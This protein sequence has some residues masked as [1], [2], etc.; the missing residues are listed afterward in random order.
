MRNTMYLVRMAPDLPFKS[1]AAA[2]REDDTGIAAAWVLAG[3]LEPQQQRVTAAPREALLARLDCA[4][5]LPLTVVISPPG[6]GKTTLLSQWHGSLRKRDDIAVAWLSLE[7]ED[8]EVSRFVVY[9]ALAIARAGVDL[10]PLAQTTRSQLHDIDA[11]GAIAALLAVI[12]ALPRRLVIVLDDYDRTRSQTVDDV[13]GRLIRHG[14]AQLHVVISSRS[15]PRLPLSDLTVRG[16]VERIEASDLALSMEEARMVLGSGI[17]S[18]AVRQLHGRTEGWAVALQL[19]G[20][21]LSAGSQ[22]TGS[23]AQFSGRSTEMAAYLA[24]Q[25]VQQLEPSLR[26]FLLETSVLDRFDVRLANAVR[27]RSDS[28][29]RFSRLIRFEGLLVPLDAEHEWYR[30]HHLFADFLRQQLRHGH[31]ELEALL[32][33][34]AA[35][36]LSVNGDLLEAV[37]HAVRAGDPALATRFVADAG[38]WELILR[39]GLGYVRPLLRHFDPKVVRETPVLNITQ[40]YLHIKLGEMS[41]ATQLLEYFRAM[42]GGVRAPHERDC[43]I[44]V[45]LLRAYLDEVCSERASVVSIAAQAEVCAA[46]DFLGRGTLYCVCAEGEL[47]IGDFAA[48]E[49]YASE[50][51]DDMRKAGS[52]VGM[53]YALFHLGQ[54][55]YYRGLLGQA[56]ATYR[57]ALTIAAHYFGIDNALKAC[58]EC[59][60]AQLLCQRGQME[61]ARS[62]LKTCIEFIETHDGWLDIFAAAYEAALTVARA[63]TQS[64]AESLALLDH[65]EKVAQDRRLRRLSE[66]VR[67]WRIEVLLDAPGSLSVDPLIADAEGESYLANTLGRPH[68]WRQEMALGMAM[69][70]WHRQAGRSGVAVKLLRTLE[71]ACTA[72]KRMLDLA[73]VHA[74]L[75]LVL[76][77]RGEI[78]AALPMLGRALDYVAM[79]QSCRVILELGMPVKTL[80]RLSLQQDPMAIAGSSRCLQIQRLL[81]AARLDEEAGSDLLSGREVEVLRELCRGSSNKQIGRLLNLSEN[82]VKFHL[83]NVFR[84]LGVKSRGAAVVTAMQRGL[85]SPAERRSPARLDSEA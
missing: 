68:C 15:V 61:E 39:H 37:K 71:T 28:G 67:A 57:E 14:G 30:Y 84:K 35:E 72:G 29:A 16:L 60:L 83:K 11:R 31:P 75:A 82:T 47:G 18:E 38:G 66:L 23:I 41:E 85:T 76:Q 59:L 49:S 6:F 27:Q 7:E 54:S 12:R 19:A 77:S 50:S 25:V 33:R 26:D 24:E 2:Y 81:E 79:E 51:L 17:S 5:R 48:A 1:D 43:T 4:L 52:P 55:Y 3:K 42:P 20:L 34:R 10:G 44:I 63:D 70:R 9:L 8:G 32:H 80:L 58:G 74:H 64:P 73:R 36:W 78:D 13:V 65:I 46:D 45:A 53:A 69:A 62:Y 56:E 40:A 21:W 22:R